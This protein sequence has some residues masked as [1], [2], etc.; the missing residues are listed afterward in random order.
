[1]TSSTGNPQPIPLP[2]AGNGPLTP[3][4]PP[5]RATS[6]RCVY[7]NPWSQ[8]MEEELQGPQGEAGL[9]AYFAPVDC[10]LIVPL[11]QESGLW[12]TALVEQWR[13]PIRAQT[14]ELP[15][16]RL[17]PGESVLAA[18]RRELAEE[19]GLQAGRWQQGGD[20]QHSDARVAGNIAL[21]AAWDCQS[22]AD[23][24]PG[25]GSEI[26]LQAFRLPLQ[27]AWSAVGQ[28]RLRQCAS[29]AAIAWALDL[30]YRDGH[31]AEAG[32]SPA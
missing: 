24:P 17:E 25:D 7:E 28:G 12:F 26:D 15:C 11:W 9:Y 1:M 10:V 31:S 29:I 32:A 13:Q 22:I 21:L 5:W 4:P 19:C 18:A 20:W 14:W 23:K 2:L 6:S 27:A 8:V 30:V 16:G 3:K